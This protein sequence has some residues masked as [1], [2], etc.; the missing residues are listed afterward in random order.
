MI[1]SPLSARFFLKSSAVGTGG[2]TSYSSSDVRSCM[3]LVAMCIPSGL[4][5]TAVHQDAWSVLILA[6]QAPQLA[7]Q[8]RTTAS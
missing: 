4:M 3:E 6:R 5:A 7:S 2:T 1:T 8:I